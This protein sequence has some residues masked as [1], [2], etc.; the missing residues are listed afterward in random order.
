MTNPIDIIANALLAADN[1][2]AEGKLNGVVN[3]GH[4]RARAARVADA[5]TQDAAIIHAAQALAADTAS[6]PDSPLHAA[7]MTI[8][9]YEHIARVVLRSVGGA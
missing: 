7:N 6:R 9:A 1:P 3:P 2:A 4:Y 5:L 8:A